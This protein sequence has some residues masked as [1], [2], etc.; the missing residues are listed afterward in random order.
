LRGANLP[1]LV[2]WGYLATVLVGF[3]A[4]FPFRTII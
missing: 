4:Y 1:R 2:V 3:I